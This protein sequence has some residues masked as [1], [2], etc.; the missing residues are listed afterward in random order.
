MLETLERQ[1][2]EHP[3]AS[4]VWLHGLGA[5]G[6]DFE[7]MVPE[8]RLEGTLSVRFVFPHAPV[9]PVTVNGGMPMRA[10]YDIVSLEGD[11]TDR[12][13]IEASAKEV[14]ALLERERER[15]IAP[16]RT[17]LAG[18]SQGGAIALHLGLRR[19]HSLA[20]LI[21][22]STYLPLADSAPAAEERPLP[23][24]MGHGDQDP[25]VPP[26]AGEASRDRLLALGYPVEW[27]RYPMG[28]AV[29]AEELAD[30]RAFL[31]RVLGG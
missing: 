17:V 4:V 6:H 9:R 16:G 31:L 14:A 10:W 2:G 3:D 22:L 8:L 19:R 23:L 12:E 11:R 30:V 24:M 28:H 18:F 25:M 27:H 15:G 5:D 1:T 7:P 13:G 29:C 26:R 20:A 21:A